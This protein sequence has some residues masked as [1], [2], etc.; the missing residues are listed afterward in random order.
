M[1]TVSYLWKNEAWEKQGGEATSPSL[2]LLFG[3]RTVIEKYPDAIEKLQ[4]ICPGSSIVTA[5][6][7]GNILDVQLLDE[8]MIVTGIEFDQTTIRAHS[9]PFGLESDET[10]GHNLASYFDAPDLVYVLLLSTSGINAGNLLKGIN[11]VFKGRVPVSG[12]VAGDDTR[13]E[14]TLVGIGTAISSA[15]VTAIGFYGTRLKVSHGSKGGWDT[16]GPIR[17]VTKCNGNVL[18]EIDNKPVLDL[19]KEYLGEKAR[20][21]PASGL[22][23]PFAIIDNTTREP[24]VRGIQNVDEATNSI[25]LYG[26]VIEGQKIQLMRANFEK[27]I[28]G[29]GE[30]AHETFL[31]QKNEPEFALLISCIARRLVL[32]QLTEEELSEAR[33]AIGPHACISGFYSY[34]ELSP[35][36]GDNACHLHN[37][38]MTITTFSEKTA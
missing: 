7:A 36:L 26:D 2:C 20:E 10:L 17:T 25:L 28:S 32:G 9:F 6:T 33:N 21:L 37:Q 23:F 24:V 27:L 1:K 11:T 12:G 16:F 8:T 30:S 35:V 3:T 22:L 4:E 13:F 5:S 38:T 31:D 15:Q 19:Y 34:S 14:K 29:A 18:Y